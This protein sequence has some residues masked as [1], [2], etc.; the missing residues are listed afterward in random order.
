MAAHYR[1]GRLGLRTATVLTACGDKPRGCARSTIAVPVSFGSAPML[2]MMVGL[3]C[4]A[5]GR[6]V[7]DRC[8]NARGRSVVNGRCRVVIYDL[9][10]MFDAVGLVP[11]VGR[12]YR[13]G[14]GAECSADDC[15]V[16]A[17]DRA[18]NRGACAPA[19]KGAPLLTV[20]NERG[21]LASTF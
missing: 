19:K 14:G 4:A 2:V 12:N 9:R 20:V 11:V 10:P 15:T 17:V 3:T 5:I 8:G 6:N 21:N 7:I 18:A 16:S 13:A 1:L